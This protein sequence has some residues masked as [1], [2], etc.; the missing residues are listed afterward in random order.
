[1][2]SSYGHDMTGAARAMGGAYVS[3]YTPHNTSG[4]YGVNHSCYIQ[5]SVLLGVVFYYMWVVYK[6]W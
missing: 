5:G 1:M 3:V 2:R 6:L 4:K